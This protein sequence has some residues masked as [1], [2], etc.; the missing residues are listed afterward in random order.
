MVNQKK[1]NTW[2]KGFLFLGL[3]LVPGSIPMF[4]LYHFW[5]KKEDNKEKKD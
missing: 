1:N 5:T 4:I 3:I 2:K